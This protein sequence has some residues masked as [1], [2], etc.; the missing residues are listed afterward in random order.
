MR[1][2]IRAVA[3]ACLAAA[4]LGA[5]ALA[6]D[7]PVQLKLAHWLPPSH[8]LHKAFQDWAASVEKASNG[9]IKSAIF[10]AQQLGKAFDH[11]DMARDGIA[12]MTYINPGY[13]PGRFPIIGAGELPFLIADGKGGSQALDAWYRKYAAQEMR[14][15]KFCLGFVHDPGGFHSR[16]KKIV[17]PEDVRGM[18]V[19]PAQATFAALVTQL[20]GTN[21]Q[22]SAPEVREILERGVADSVAFPWGSVVLFG[23]DK[24]T[25][26]HMDAPLYVTTFAWVLN[27]GKYDGL[28]ATQ[29]KV[30]DDHCTNEWARKVAEPWADFEAGGRAKIRAESGHEVYTL[31][32]D[33]LAAWK[34][35]AEPLQNA[36]ADAVRKAGA[37]PD[38]VMKELKGE[39][40]KFNAA[41]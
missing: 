14:D 8:P 3:L 20:G 31:T 16:A 37:D 38:A 35:A 4:A 9:T 29:K 25:K 10:P 7:A 5:P 41:M 34:K 12:D 32:A 39:L 19:R 23:I 27:K 33:Q 18:K 30:I 40:S 36:W 13:Q 22:S 17:V 28:S 24:V 1:S 21:V 2:R 15:V 11:Y 26:Q 6:Q